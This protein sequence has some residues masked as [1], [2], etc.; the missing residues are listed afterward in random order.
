[1]RCMQEVI[2]IENAQIKANHLSPQDVIRDPPDIN[3]PCNLGH[4]SHFTRDGCYL[5]AKL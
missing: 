5:L 1:M 2:E 3:H 4:P